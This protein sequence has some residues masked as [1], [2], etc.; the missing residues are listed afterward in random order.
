MGEGLPAACT[1]DPHRREPESA[2]DVGAAAWRVVAAMH[3]GHIAEQ[4]DLQIMGIGRSALK[5]D[6]RHVGTVFG[7]PTN[8][9]EVVDVNPVVGEYPLEEI[10]RVAPDPGEPIEIK[11]FELFSGL[12][13]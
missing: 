11:P 13:C 3:H 2:V 7:F 10:P 1:T 9:A 5:W 6:H 12:V 4:S 8:L